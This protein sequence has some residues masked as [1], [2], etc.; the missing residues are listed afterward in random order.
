MELELLKLGTGSGGL[1][2]ALAKYVSPN[3]KVYSYDNK[4]KHQKVARKNL[5][6]LG[7]AEFVEFKIR[8]AAE[9]FDETEI[10]SVILDLPNPWDIIPET[11]KALMGGGILLIF[12]PTYAQVNISPKDGGK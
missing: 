10:D 1:T 5:E 6:K 8:D 9:G 4:E 2:S 7:L 3:G 12:V 11:Y